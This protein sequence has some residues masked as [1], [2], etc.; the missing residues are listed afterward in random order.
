[1]DNLENYLYIALAVIY[2]LS[3]VLKAKKQVPPQKQNPAQRQKQPARP[4]RQT[5][6]RK[7]FSFEDILKEFEKNLAGEQFEEEKPMPVEEIAYEK[8]IQVKPPKPE[9]KP[10]HSPYESYEGTSYESPG[11]RKEVI[12]PEIFSRSE[13]YSLKEDLASQYIKMLQNP[14]GFKNAIVLSE[15]INRKYF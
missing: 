14:E 3:R 6:P 11:N 13:K 8:P 7:A 9:T 15:I 1:M 5:Q 12:K 4:I 10:Y 2:I